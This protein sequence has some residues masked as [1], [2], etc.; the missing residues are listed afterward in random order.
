MGKEKVPTVIFGVGASG[1]L[2]LY[3]QKVTQ[4]MKVWRKTMKF[5]NPE[6]GEV[7]HTI[8]QAVQNHCS[9]HCNGRACPYW[10]SAGCV[11][12]LKRY[13]VDN[14]HEATRLMGYEVVEDEVYNSPTEYPCSTC[15]HGWGSLSTEGIKSCHETCQELQA[16]KTSKYKKEA[17]MDKPRICEILGVE[18]GESFYIR[19]LEGIEFWIMDDGTFSTRPSNAPGSTKALLLTLDRPERIIRKPRFTEQEVER[20][21]AVKVLYPEILY[22]QAD[23]RYLRGLNK[24]KESI[25]LDCVVSWSPSLRSDETVTLDEIIGGAE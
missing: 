14:P 23:D 12:M 19:G 5:R 24:E 20:A 7:F 25:F 17:N 8:R 16:W 13:T 4:K 1:R 18:P 22:L 15:D 21:K 3:L 9:F 6:T 2:K 11:G 10:E